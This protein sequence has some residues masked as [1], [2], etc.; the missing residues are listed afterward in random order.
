M[1]LV[2]VWGQ[3]P[4][5]TATLRNNRP[6]R[7]PLEERGSRATNTN[8]LGALLWIPAFAGMTDRGINLGDAGH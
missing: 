1:V 8:V 7:H 3:S 2:G 6:I 5:I 4:H